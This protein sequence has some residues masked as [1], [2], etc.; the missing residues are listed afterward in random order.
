MDSSPFQHDARSTRQW[1]NYR[2]GSLA[3]AVHYLPMILSVYTPHTPSRV[4]PWMS[5]VLNN[6]SRGAAPFTEGCYSDE[7][8]TTS[9]SPSP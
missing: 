1:I 5:P 4:D 9:L 6:G 3:Y 8:G 2:K 7:A